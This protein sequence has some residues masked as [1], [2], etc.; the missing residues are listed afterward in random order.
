MLVDNIGIL[1]IEEGNPCIV[2][3]VIDLKRELS[4]SSLRNSSSTAIGRFLFCW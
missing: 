4:A 2:C 1:E 3:P